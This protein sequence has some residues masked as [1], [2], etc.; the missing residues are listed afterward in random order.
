[1]SVACE[2]IPATVASIGNYFG[3]GETNVHSFLDSIDV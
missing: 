2:K 1:M 3:T